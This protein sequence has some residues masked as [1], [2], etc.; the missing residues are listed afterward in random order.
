M[1]KSCLFQPLTTN[2]S[3]FL[4]V[5]CASVVQFLLSGGARDRDPPDV[6]YLN[7]LPLANLNI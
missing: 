7:Y 1:Q 5:L 4:C 3:N 2:H 6:R